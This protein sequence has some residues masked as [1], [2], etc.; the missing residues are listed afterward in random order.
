MAW[1]LLAVIVVLTLA[2][3]A[4]RPQTSVSHTMEH[5]SIFLVTGIA[6]GIGYGRWDAL[7]YIA[8]VVFCA[9]L[10]ITQVFDPGRHA[11]MSDFLVDFIAMWVGLWVGS[12]LSKRT[13]W[14]NRPD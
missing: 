13:G 8:A 14:G 7:L 9:G 11:R 4:L 3:P 6:F 10:E 12:L 1:V 2:P 5:A